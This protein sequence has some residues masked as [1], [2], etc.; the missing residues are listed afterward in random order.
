MT[1]S[2]HEWDF[3]MQISKGQTEISKGHP[4][5]LRG[6]PNDIWKV[7]GEAP[8]YSP[9]KADIP[10]RHSWKTASS[11]DHTKCVCRSCLTMD[12]IWAPLKRSSN[13]DPWPDTIWNNGIGKF[14]DHNME[15]LSIT[16]KTCIIEQWV[17]HVSLSNKWL[18]SYSLP[19]L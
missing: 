17:T 1:S 2:E 4:R 13:I 16:C 11:G 12:T 5:F 18:Y 7:Q 9:C 19:L 10:E 15:D 6:R 14:S 8:P 3:M